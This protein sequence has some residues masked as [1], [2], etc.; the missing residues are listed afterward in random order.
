MI[1]ADRP[2]AAVQIPAGGVGRDRNFGV[3]QPFAGDCGGLVHCHGHGHGKLRAGALAHVDAPV[4]VVGRRG[5]FLGLVRFGGLV[6]GRVAGHDVL[7]P[8]LAGLVNVGAA[9]VA[10][11]LPVRPDVPLDVELA[12]APGGQGLVQQIGGAVIGPVDAGRGFAVHPFVEAVALILP[13]KRDEPFAAHV[14][15]VGDVVLVFT[16]SRREG[17][18]QRD[19]VIPRDR[20]CAGDSFADCTVGWFSVGRFGSEISVCPHIQHPGGGL[21]A[22]DEST[23]IG[24]AHVGRHLGIGK[25]SAVREGHGD[26]AVRG[27]VDGLQQHWHGFTGGHPGFIRLD[28]KQGFV[29]VAAG[30]GL[31]V[32]VQHREAEPGCGGSGFGGSFGCLFRCGRF[33]RSHRLAFGGR[34]GRLRCGGGCI[35]GGRLCN[36]RPRR[37]RGQC[38]A[39]AG[40]QAQPRQQ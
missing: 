5:R 35:A 13:L 10:G 33:R 31:V 1:R 6:H 2:T 36:G 38:R 9:A 24:C 26:R 3:I 14:G 16:G 25:D 17:G 7:P 18:E 22:V 28:G 40:Q 15:H 19:L 30:R 39:A 27:G 37:L 23:G 8:G 11:L 29:D 21:L 12:A 4:G 20:D 34:L 32:R